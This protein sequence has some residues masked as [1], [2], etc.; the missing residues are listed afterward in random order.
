MTACSVLCFR[1]ASDACQRLSTKPAASHAHVLDALSESVCLARSV[2]P[3]QAVLTFVSTMGA[4]SIRLACNHVMAKLS[5][6]HDCVD[7]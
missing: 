4:M 1:K 6:R 2:K 7:V 3:A 5:Q